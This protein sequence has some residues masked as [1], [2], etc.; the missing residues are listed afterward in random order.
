MKV[1]HGVSTKFEHRSGNRIV[2]KTG[3]VKPWELDLYTVF[4]GNEDIEC[5]LSDSFGEPPYVGEVLTCVFDVTGMFRGDATLRLVRRC[6]G[7]ALV[8]AFTP[9]VAALVLAMKGL[10]VESDAKPSRAA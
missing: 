8:T 9:E 7:P 6:D 3:E 1:L 10:A 4:D 2:E 5:T